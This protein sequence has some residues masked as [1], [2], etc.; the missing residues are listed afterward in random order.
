VRGR[1]GSTAAGGAGVVAGA[2]GCAVGACAEAPAP[3]QRKS[4]SADT[5]SKR[6]GLDLM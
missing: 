1:A 3:E 2:A 6:L 4:R 5:I